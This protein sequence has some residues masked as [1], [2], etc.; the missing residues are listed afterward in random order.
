[1]R[2]RQQIERLKP[3]GEVDRFTNAQMLGLI[4][5]VLLDLRDLEI[6]AAESRKLAETMA[7]QFVQGQKA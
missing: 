2:D 4:L 1:M 6:R 7:M 3:H 5:E